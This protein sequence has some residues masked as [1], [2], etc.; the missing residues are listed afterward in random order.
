MLKSS[1]RAVGQALMRNPFA[2]EVPCHRVV[3]TSLNIGGF[4]GTWGDTSQVRQK[5]DMLLQEGVMFDSDTT[6]AAVCLIPAADLE[7]SLLKSEVLTV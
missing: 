1:P 2:P 7:Q 4:N 6:I 5:K 3:S